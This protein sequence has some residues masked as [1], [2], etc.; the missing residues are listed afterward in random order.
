MNTYPDE[1]NWFAR[2]IPYISIIGTLILMFFPLFIIFSV[3]MWW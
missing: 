1:D 3:I 2:Q